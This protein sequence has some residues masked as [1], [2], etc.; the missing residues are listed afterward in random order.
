MSEKGDKA[1]E[2]NG[3]SEKQNTTA[4]SQITVE[5]PE[6]TEPTDAVAIVAQKIAFSGPIPPPSMLKDYDDISPGLADRI[7]GIA[8]KEQSI[9]DKSNSR[10]LWND[11]VRVSG[12]VI[13]S[14]ALCAIA[15]FGLF[16]GYPWAAIAIGISGAIPIVVKAFMDRRE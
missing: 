15:A 13:V 11:F 2:D 6:G 14:L 9:R 7:V 3:N 4:P 1:A 12:S 8:E 5:I 16:L 10:S